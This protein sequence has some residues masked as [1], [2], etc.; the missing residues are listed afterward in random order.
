MHLFLSIMEGKRLIP[1]AMYPMYYC[2]NISSPVSLF[3]FLKLLTYEHF[4]VHFKK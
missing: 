1:S 3:I 2:I 4:G